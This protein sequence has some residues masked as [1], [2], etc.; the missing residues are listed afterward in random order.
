MLKISFSKN[1]ILKNTI[2]LISGLIFGVGLILSQMVNPQK[3][4]GFLNV[5]GA[6]DISLAL[7]MVGALMVSI[8]G[9]FIAKRKSQ[10]LIGE[11]IILPNKTVIDK[12]L[13][14]GAALFGIGWGIAGICPA[15]AIVLLGTGQWQALVFIVA[16]II[17]II[18]YQQVIK[19]K[20]R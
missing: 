9:V 6:W 11:A 1:D 7:V 10:S 8:I 13:I 14:L 17:G 18:A 20:L 16:M 3:V 2:G 19:P 5:F 4:L 15:P 12:P